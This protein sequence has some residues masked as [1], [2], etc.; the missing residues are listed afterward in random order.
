M[1]TLNRLLTVRFDTVSRRYIGE[2]LMTRFDGSEE[3]VTSSVI[4]T[5]GWPLERVA[6]MLI[7]AARAA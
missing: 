6:R 1:Q 4:G 2:V 3:A 5:P 7:G